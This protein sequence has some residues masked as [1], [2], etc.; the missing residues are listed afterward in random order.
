MYISLLRVHTVEKSFFSVTCTRI[1]NSLTIF[2]KQYH[3]D[4]HNQNVQKTKYQFTYEE[5]D[6][7][8]NTQTFS[9]L[10]VT[11]SSLFSL[12]S[13]LDFKIWRSKLFFLKADQRSCTYAFPHL[14]LKSVE[15]SIESTKINHSLLYKHP[16]EVAE[17]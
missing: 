16:R 10:E 1:L 17:N 8:D 4:H 11:S 13:A 3:S 7:I 9:N 15:L 5:N 14:F 6:S 2:I 12:S